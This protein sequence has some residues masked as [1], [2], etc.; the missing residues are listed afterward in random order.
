MY[1][2]ID[3][4]FYGVESIRWIAY[5]Y[6]WGSDRQQD[7]SSGAVLMASSILL[8]FDMF[9]TLLAP[10]VV[11]SIHM[12]LWTN[13]WGYKLSSELSD[14]IIG[15]TLLSQINIHICWQPHNVGSWENTMRITGVR[16]RHAMRMSSCRWIFCLW[17]VICLN[18][19]QNY[20]LAVSDM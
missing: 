3:K 5:I 2:S 11:T 14:E 17:N 7:L 1:K 9:H 10:G 8:T 13:G 16:R 6:R 15:I 19:S 18:T 20:F 4:S 12:D